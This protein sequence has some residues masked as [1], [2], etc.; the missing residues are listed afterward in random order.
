MPSPAAGPRPSS[1]TADPLAPGS[2]PRSA[3]AARARFAAEPADRI[4]ARIAAA[5]ESVEARA[6]DAD[7]APLLPA[8]ALD[9]ARKLCTTVAA[10]GGLVAS[11]LRAIE[12]MEARGRAA[13][14]ALEE[15]RDAIVRERAQALGWAGRIA[16]RSYLVESQRSSGGHPLPAVEAMLWEQAALEQEEDRARAR[17]AQL[18]A[19][20]RAC[21]ADIER[22]DE[23]MS[24][25]LLV[26]NACL[27]GRVAALRALAVEAWLALAALRARLR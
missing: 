25:E 10:V 4:A 27:E 5:L 24:Q 3:E 8:A 26:V 9:E 6:S 22:H 17:A 2:D 12:A 19:A 15:R 13:R 16:E 1:P 21:E 11:D 7:G 20:V 18:T 23:R 14:T